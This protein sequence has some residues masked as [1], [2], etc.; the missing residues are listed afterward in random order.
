MKLKLV[1]LCACLLGACGG[2]PPA[3]MTPDGTP[4]A[5]AEQVELP[6]VDSDP[7][8][9]L[10]LYPG[11]VITVTTVSQET[12]QLPGLVVDETGRVHLPL[13]GDVMVG[14]LGIGEAQQRIQEALQQ[15]DR[16]VRATVTV[17]DLAGHRA[18]VLGAVQ[19][20]GHVNV[21]PGLRL[22]DLLA[23]TGGPQ[24]QV[25]EEA[26]GPTGQRVIADLS[27]ARLHRAGEAL[28][29]SV[30]AALRGDPRHN[31]RIRPGDH[32]YV[33]AR[34][35]DRIVVLGAVNG[36]NVFPFR[37]GM[38]M[39]E[40]LA[41]AAGTTIDADNADI[42][43]VR[44]DLAAPQVYVA[45]LDD[46]RDGDGHDVQLEPGD[47]LYVTDHWIADVGEVLDRLGPLLATTVTIG[48]TTAIIMTR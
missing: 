22:A 25:I 37:S 8:A 28:P 5:P 3:P 43:I 41:L 34:V 23:L 4:F 11:D 27:A 26:P 15:F 42:R 19:N 33:P 47:I 45:S 14:G 44:G 40:A 48:L 32:L 20:P 31:I 16:F 6:G 39:T 21:T 38:R 1:G 24:T 17:T 30:D 35:F 29:V 13:G 10:T 7:P 2:L 12:T 18:T 36:A 46:V 9:P